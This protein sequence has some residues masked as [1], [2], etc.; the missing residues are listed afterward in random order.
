MDPKSQNT[1]QIY[2]TVALNYNESQ[3]SSLAIHELTRTIVFTDED[4]TDVEI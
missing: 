3:L 4:V 1:M 2:D